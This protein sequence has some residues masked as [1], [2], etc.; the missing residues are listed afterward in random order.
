MKTP[1][2]FS[3]GDMLSVAEYGHQGIDNI[4]TG[5]WREPVLGNRR[6]RCIISIPNKHTFVK[7]NLHIDSANYPSAAFGKLPNVKI[8]TSHINEPNI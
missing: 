2:L 5:F 4:S 1:L 3:A 7:G 6:L 8:H